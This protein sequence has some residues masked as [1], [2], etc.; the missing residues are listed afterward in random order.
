[1][2][3]A[4]VISEKVLFVDIETVPMVKNFA[5][6]SPIMQKLFTQ[7]HLFSMEIGHP[8]EESFVE[9]A[10]IWAEFG[11]LICISCGY[12][13][14]NGF[15]LKSFFGEQEADILKEFS[16][17]LEEHY[18]TANHF[19]CAHNGKEFD[20]P[21]LCRRMIIHGIKIPDILDLQGKKP[22]ENPHLDTMALW[23]FG[24]YKHF[25]SLELLTEVLHISS[26]KGKT[27]GSQ[28][29]NLYYEEG[30]W[31]KI[32]NYCEGDVLSVAQIFRRY[33]QEPLLKVQ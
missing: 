12:I 5:D 32:V 17:F 9:R 21:F 23:R 7:K 30:A 13:S 10:G 18:S 4:Q 31:E 27:H 1:M 24:D 11:K 8:I 6:L 16:A 3:L 19:L 29:Y 14:Q 25:T 33:R 15:R 28:V 22:W 20:F 2:K 26:P